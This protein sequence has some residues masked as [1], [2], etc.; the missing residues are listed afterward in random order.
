MANY[1]SAD[2][3]ARAL[4]EAGVPSDQDFPSSATWYRWLSDGQEHWVGQIAI[5][6]PWV[7]MGDPTLIT[8]ADSGETYTFGTDDDGEDITP[9]AVQVYAAKDGRLL[10]PNTYW[11]PN[12]DYVW[13]G[14]KIRFARGKTKQFSDGPYARF[15][16]P[17]DPITSGDEPTL[18]PVRARKLIVYRACALWAAR[19]GLKN[20]S[21][22]Y[23]LEDRAWLGVP[24]RGDYG[25]LGELKN[26]N[27]LQGMESYAPQPAGIL[28][29]VNT[30]WGY[31]AAS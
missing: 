30:G 9:L 25:L 29:G 2:L 21:V 31:T 7:M 12:G 3:L 19:G 17:P 18:K 24:A 4:D 16:T 11:N 26:Q 15:V 28:T 20:P 6:V 27:P 22:F 5:H 8:S 1:D 14:D 10:Y 23:D 13:E